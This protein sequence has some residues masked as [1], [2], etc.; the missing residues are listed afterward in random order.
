VG[1]EGRRFELVRLVCEL[2]V[3]VRRQRLLG[4]LR[5][6]VGVEPPD[7]GAV[8]LA[9]ALLGEAVGRLEQPKRRVHPPVA[10]AHAEEPA[11][12]RKSRAARGPCRVSVEDGDATA[13]RAG[14]LVGVAVFC[15]ACDVFDAGRVAA[16]TDVSDRLAVAASFADRRHA[17]QRCRRAG[18]ERA[19]DDGRR[20]GQRFYGALRGYMN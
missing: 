9:T 19:R 6:P 11:H 2:L 13:A 5:A 10:T 17:R 12:R 3:L 1:D 16:I 18:P 15:G 8:R 20:V 7:T 14:Q 4:D